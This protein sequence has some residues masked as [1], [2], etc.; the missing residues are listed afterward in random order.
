MKDEKVIALPGVTIEPSDG[1]APNMDIVETLEGLLEEAKRGD[2]KW[3]GVAMVDHRN[4]G[5]S[6]YSPTLENLTDGSLVTSAMGATSY[7]EK[8]FGRNVLEGAVAVYSDDNE[9]GD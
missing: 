9:A 6:L 1:P 2:I 7:L 3:I 5:H 8:R 4:I